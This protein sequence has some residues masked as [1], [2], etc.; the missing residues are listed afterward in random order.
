MRKFYNEIEEV[1]EVEKKINERGIPFSREL[2]F[3]MSDMFSHFWFSD[4]SLDFDL[5]YEPKEILD[6]E[7]V[8][9]DWNPVSDNMMKLLT[10]E[11][12]LERKFM[13]LEERIENYWV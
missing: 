13:N 1:K 12:R 9:I 6:D 7:T 8:V 3:A 4:E 11:S 10:L 5:K 2:A